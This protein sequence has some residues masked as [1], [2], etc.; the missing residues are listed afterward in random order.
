MPQGQMAASRMSRANWDE[1]NS[2][3]ALYVPSTSS[4]LALE[5]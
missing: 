4:K 5:N 1:N 2:S 3:E